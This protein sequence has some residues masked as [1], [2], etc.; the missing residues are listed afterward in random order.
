[1]ARMRSQTPVL[2]ELEIDQEIAA[3]RAGLP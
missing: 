1:V 3:Y 2:S